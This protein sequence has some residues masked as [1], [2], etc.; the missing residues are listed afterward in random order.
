MAG[1]SYIRS[2]IGRRLVVMTVLFSSLI[3]LALTVVQLTLEYSEEMDKHSDNRQIITDSLLHS[4]G[5]SVWTYDDAQIALQLQGIVNMPNIERA[6]L[7]LPEGG[8]FELGEVTSGIIEEVAFDVP[9]RIEGH[10]SIIAQLTIVSGL[11]QTYWSLAKLAGLILVSNA[12]KASLVV[13]FMLYLLDRLIGQRM[14]QVTDYLQNY[15]QDKEPRLLSLEGRFVGSGDEFD[16]LVG[17]LNDMQHRIH[18]EQQR[19]LAESQ[20]RTEV[21]LQLAKQNEQLLHLERQI[22]LG[23]MAS[24]LAH[25]LNQPLTSVVGYSDICRRLL[26]QEPLNVKGLKEGLDKLSANADRATALIRRTRDVVKSRGYRKQTLDA[27]VLVQGACQ[28]LSRD[29]EAHQIRL[30]MSPPAEPLY[31]HVDKVQME[32][33]VINLLR[34]AMDALGEQEPESRAIRVDVDSIADGVRLAITDNGCG[35]PPELEG[36]LFRPFV[37]SKK[38]GYG[39]GLAISQ[40]IVEAM[41]GCI[42]ARNELLGGSRFCVTLP[43]CNTPAAQETGNKELK[44]SVDNGLKTGEEHL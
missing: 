30:V 25:E 42:T 40:G 4:L 16:L 11:D 36:E 1:L 14:R 33:V 10:Y 12:A 20:K 24:T 22:S 23:E 5:E 32:Q 27:A 21:Q 37:T 18:Q 35:L 15:Q 44:S 29:L 17:S 41:G 6:L 43:R 34:N 7:V 8:R 38:D 39:V 2:K 19:V 26:G 9:Y 13:F 3:T 31:V 28:L